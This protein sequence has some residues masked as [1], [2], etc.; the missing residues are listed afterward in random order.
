MT[1]L[2]NAKKQLRTGLLSLSDLRE[3]ERILG[4]LKD[5]GSYVTTIYSNV[6]MYFKRNGYSVA[7]QGIAY[8]I[9][10]SNLYRGGKNGSNN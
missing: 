5:K 3:C 7:H 6:A 10:K 2:L 1:A 4:E 9:T 8:M